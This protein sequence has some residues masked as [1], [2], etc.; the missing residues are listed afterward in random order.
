MARPNQQPTGPG[1]E[2]LRKVRSELNSAL[3]LLGVFSIAIN[4]LLLVPSLY[5]M[6]VY[7]RVL[8]SGV[9]ETLIYITLIAA[10]SIAVYAALEALRLRALARIGEWIEDRLFEPVFAAAMGAERGVVKTGA[11]EGTPFNDLRTVRTFLS[12]PTLPSLCDV[13]W[14]PVFLLGCTLIHPDLGL[15]GLVFA[16]LIVGLALINDRVTKPA[17]ERVAQGHAEAQRVLAEAARNVDTVA[18]MGM[19]RP[20]AKKASRANAASMA[21]LADATDRGTVMIGAGKF[22]RVVAQICTLALGAY[23]SLGGHIT[24]GGMIA[25]SILLSRALA[26]LDQS[27]A[28]WRGLQQCRLSWTR[29]SNLLNAAGHIIEDPIALP[30]PEGK[31]S[32]EGLTIMTPNNER[33]ILASVSLGVQP[34][35]TVAFIG[36]SGSGKS[37]LCRAIVSSRTPARGVVRLDGG[38]VMLW[39]DDQRR[40]YIGYLAQG[41][42]LF[43]GRVRDVIA[44][45]DEPDD[46]AVVAAAKLAGCHELILSLPQGYETMLH[47]GG[48][49]LS[50][51]Q[52]QRIALARAVYGETR[53]VVLDEPNAS[54][55]GEGERA[56]VNCIAALKQRKVT[57]LIVTHKPAL[58]HLADRVAVMQNGQIVKLGKATDVL[59]E[60]VA[61]ASSENVRAIPGGARS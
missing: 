47:N 24:P 28:A 22:L 45:F 7:D 5:M 1:A 26:P 44:R 14:M 56:L 37:T 15:L 13:P 48:Q 46:E 35:E 43:S 30:T 41:T 17:T 36:P 19:S 11:Q 9:V 27:I 16:V 25:S 18:A 34:G 60:L 8:R 55:D 54:L 33:P 61:P 29:I 57:T 10:A 38:D 6:Q 51:G 21:L 31:L 2:T 23:L 12:G 42:E 59:R 40:K 50:G 49:M 53:L 20:L 4:L 32:I 39:R 3:W 52:R 58:A